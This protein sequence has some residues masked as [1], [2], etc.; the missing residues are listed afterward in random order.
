MDDFRNRVGN[1]VR[2]KE[3]MII[4]RASCTRLDPA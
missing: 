2:M 3:R 4:L 1:K